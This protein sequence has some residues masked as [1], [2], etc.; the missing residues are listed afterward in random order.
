MNG[1]W[2]GGGR[3]LGSRLDIGLDLLIIRAERSDSQ[4]TTVISVLLHTVLRLP[5]ST[6]RKKGCV[7]VISE[8]LFFGY[9]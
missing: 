3:C 5:L 6:P 4:P 8:A 9:P 2:G 7:C 1:D